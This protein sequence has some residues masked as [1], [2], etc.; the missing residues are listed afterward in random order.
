MTASVERA[1]LGFAALCAINGAFVAPVAR[2]TTEAGN[3]L[4]VAAATT[5]FAAL[6]ALCVL[7]VRGQLGSLVRGPDAGV[8]VGLGALG[9]T[10]PSLLFFL[11]TARTSAL[12]AVV[13]LQ[14]EP[15]YALLFAWLV[16]GHRLTLRRVASV[17]LLLAGIVCAV[18]GKSAADPIGIA[19]LLAT[20]VAWQ[21]SHL[22]VLRRLTATPPEVLTGARYVWGG[23]WLTLAAAVLSGLG[24]Q[25][26]WPA[27]LAD[28]QLPVLALQGVVLSF[29]GTMLWYQSIARLDLARATAIVVPSI[30]LL[31]LVTAFA[32]VGESATARQLVGLSLVAAGVLSFALAPHAIESLARVPTQTA[33]IVAEAGDEAGGD[34]A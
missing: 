4:Y 15:A 33:P 23:L 7:G 14:T 16:L 12:D 27:R 9:T 6:A 34:A 30:P 24:G 32:I 3:P 11:G 29:V 1:G 8:L 10:V 13:C 31:S 2:L 22:V 19:L 25:V 5:L 18:A 20:P 17:A 28:A 21:L 26:L